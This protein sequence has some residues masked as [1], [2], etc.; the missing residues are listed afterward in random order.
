[1]MKNS[2]R[3][4]II[5]ITYIMNACI[6]LSYFPAAW[7]SAVTV[8]I[9]KP[10][11]PGTE[12]SSYRP[13][14][15][16]SALSKLFERLLLTRINEHLE[17]THLIPNVQFGFRPGHSTS[18]Q[19]KRIVRKIKTG[20]QQKNSSGIVL[21]DLK[22]A[23]DSVWHDGIIH[24][25]VQA[26]FP[27]YLT[28]IIQR[29]LTNRSFRV[30][31]NKTMSRSRQIEAGV[32]QGAVLS[33]VLFNLFMSDLPEI[34]NCDT[35]QF[36]DDVAFLTSN[37]RAASIKKQLQTAVNIF[38]KYVKQW[39]LMLNP[40]KTE[41]VFFTRRRVRKAFPRYQIKVEGQHVEW[42]RSAKYLGVIL[43]Q[44][45]T[46]KE[47]VENSILK[48]GKCFK[49]LYSIMNRN[50]KL[51]PT[52]KLRLYKSILR[53][54]LT[55][56]APVWGQCAKSHINKMQIFQNRMLKTC[57]K[58]PHRHPT[59]DV[60]KLSATEYVNEFIERLSLKFECSSRVVDNPLINS[61]F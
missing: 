26:N 5:A 15:L 31:I 22:S 47:H 9:R 32:P 16:L 57:L 44:K 20:L 58:L 10:G 25:M 55:Y 21:L 37:K 42:K 6:M 53:P 48:S 59:I 56:A 3:K 60:H 46:F 27:T 51:H 35:A 41:T 19:V 36:A 17:E 14:S 50:S 2:S 45:L 1:M 30:K 49:L 29:F 18:H 7:K 43:D 8:P 23:F 39:K 11:K 4:C 33:P 38:S 34:P 13:I 52:N 61:L 40:M 12:V 28:K 24:K 54:I